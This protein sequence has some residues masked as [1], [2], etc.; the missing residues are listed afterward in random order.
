MKTIADLKETGTITKVDSADDWT[1]RLMV[2]GLV[3]G[4]QIEYVSVAIGNDPIE[5]K[6]FG[7]SMSIQQKY[8][9][10]FSVE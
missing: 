3:E 10:K 2:L 8:A 6:L 4:A 9:K 1:Q 5:I 7:A